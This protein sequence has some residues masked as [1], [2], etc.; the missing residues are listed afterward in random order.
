MTGAV[1]LERLERSYRRLL[2][3]YPTEYRA[4]YGEEMIG[5]LM[6]ASTPEQRRPATREAFGLISTGL[7][8]RLRMTVRATHSPAWSDAARA[9]GYL[10]AVTMAAIFGFQTIAVA[11]H[12]FSGWGVSWVAAVVA[13]GWTLTAVAAGLGLRRLAAVSAIAATAGVSVAVTRSYTEDPGAVVTAWWILVLAVTGAAALVM[14]A[15]ADGERRRPLGTRS[16]VAVALAALLAV[17]APALE[18]LTVVVTRY[19]ETVW[20]ESYRPPFNWLILPMIGYRPVASITVT[21]LVVV[22][23]VVVVRLS[24][25]VRRRVVLLALPT[26]VTALV[27]ALTFN[28]FLQASPRFSPPVYLVPPQWITLLATPVLVFIVGVWLVA[29]YERKLASGALLR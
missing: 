19:D 5:V 28:G 7:A 2:A 15:R 26:A 1:G 22:L 4:M 6:T 3:C 18:W 14:L 27:V 17:A 12:P 29:R 11:A 13:I 9:F 25:A 10:A 24:P 23:T 8:A 21:A 16:R 20:T